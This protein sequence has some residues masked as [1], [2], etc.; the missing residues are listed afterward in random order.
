MKK[1]LTLVALVGATTVSFAQGTVNFANTSGTLISAGGV[2]MPVFAT[3]PFNFAIFLAPSSTTGVQGQTPSLT[4]PAFQVV[5]GTTV[6]T[7]GAGRIASKN[8]L[9]VGTAGGFGPGSTVDFI[10]RG[11]SANAGA[12]WAEALA[13]WNNGN[14]SSSMYIG[15]STIGNDLVLG[16]G[17]LFVPTTFG[18]GVNQVAGFNMP[19]VAVPEPTSMV[20]AGLGAASLLLFRRRK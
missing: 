10:V 5:G 3:S 7:T 16:G 19:L 1:L 15:S 9:D 14:P 20:L 6:N 18:V 17:A 12:T 4:D 13:F 11:W 8:G 2:A